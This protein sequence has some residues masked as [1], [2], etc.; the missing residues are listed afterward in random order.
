MSRDW[1]TPALKGGIFLVINL[2]LT[3]RLMAFSQLVTPVFLILVGVYD[4]ISRH[5]LNMLYQRVL[6]VIRLDIS[7]NYHHSTLYHMKPNTAS[8]IIYIT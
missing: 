2:N 8:A 1:W 4:T 7:I 6:V 5:A 3:D